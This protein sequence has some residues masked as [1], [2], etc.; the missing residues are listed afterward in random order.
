MKGIASAYNV[1]GKTRRKENDVYRITLIIS[2]PQNNVLLL[3]KAT[4]T[5][6]PQ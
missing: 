3:L 4:F 6:N 2:E 1:A 5:Q